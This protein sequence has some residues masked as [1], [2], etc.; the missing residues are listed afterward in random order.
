MLMKK[1]I[2][3]KSQDI[4]SCDLV[5][6]TRHISMSGA[7]RRLAISGAIWNG[8]DCPHW[9]RVDCKLTSL[10]CGERATTRWCLVQTPLLLQRPSLPRQGR[11]TTAFRSRALYSYRTKC[12]DR[13]FRAIRNAKIRASNLSQSIWIVWTKSDNRT[14]WKIRRFRN[15]KENIDC[16]R[17]KQSH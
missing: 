9:T 11:T 5:E 15:S 3:K 1:L 6:R 13:T 7:E 16:K 10:E 2:I 8:R 4:L 17:K 14:V 12:A